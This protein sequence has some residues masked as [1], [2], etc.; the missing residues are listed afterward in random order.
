MKKMCVRKE[1]GGLVLCREYCTGIRSGVSFFEN[2]S[3]PTIRLVFGNLTHREDGQSKGDSGDRFRMESSPRP[4]SLHLLV[5]DSVGVGLAE[6]ELSTAWRV[7][8]WA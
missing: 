7:C 4:S 1:A 3:G 5:S 2:D 8:C 6:A